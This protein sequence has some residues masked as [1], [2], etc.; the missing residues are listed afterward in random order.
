MTERRLY[1]IRHGHASHRSSSETITPLGRV[2]DPPLDPNG[3]EQAEALC[4]RLQ[5]MPDP[6]GLYVSPLG[7]A[8]ETIAPYEAATGRRAEVVDDLAEWFGGDWE[9]M[10]FEELIGEHPEMPERVL[11]QNPIG[12]LA[13]NSEPYDA[14]GRRVEGAVEAGLA[15][16]PG[17]DVWMICH[18]GVINAYVGHILQ[19]HRDQ[20][21]FFLPPNTSINTVRVVGEERHVWFLA[22]DTHLTQPGLFEER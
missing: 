21:M 12:E 9:F 2:A 22:D 1:L 3:T 15:A 17:G 18:G 19:I 4:R 16:S 20:E 6:A 11:L 10:E 8:R 7:R 5:Q 14:F 13:P